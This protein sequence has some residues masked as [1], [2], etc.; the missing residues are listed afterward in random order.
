LVFKSKPLNSSHSVKIGSLVID[1]PEE[2]PFSAQA[3]PIG[4]LKNSSRSN[5]H[6]GSNSATFSSPRPVVASLN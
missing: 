5:L 4:I 1:I 3:G 2:S 6:E